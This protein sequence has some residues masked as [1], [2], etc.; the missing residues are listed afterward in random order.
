MNAPL[1]PARKPRIATAALGGCFGCHMSLC[2]LDERLLQLAEWVD[3]DRSPL[4][5]IKRC[6]PCDIGLIEGAVCND[7]NVHVLREFREHCTV[8]VAVGACAIHGGL[9]AQRNHLPVAHCLRQV[10]RT[11]SGVIQ[12]PD[13]PEL[14]LLLDR[15]V[16]VGD[17]VRIDH[18]LP[19]CPPSADAIWRFLT[20]MLAGRTPRLGQAMLRFD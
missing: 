3:I 11:D 1:M 20:D 7:E 19:G 16:P 18:F 8:L 13:D 5:D 14:P 15:V 4:T 6:G 9:P 10:Y 12:V 17:V 2:D